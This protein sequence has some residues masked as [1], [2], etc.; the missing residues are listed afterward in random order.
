MTALGFIGAFLPVMPT[1]VFLLLA[2]F[3]FARS[4]P[5]F[6][7]WLL[8]H[9]QFGGLIR[10]WRAGRGLTLRAK[11]TAVS[12]IVVTVGSSALFFVP[13]LIGKLILAAVGIGVS[14]YL[15]TRPTKPA[16]QDG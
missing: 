1:T 4:S 12:L 3:F 13:S 15:I 14:S 2:A 11:I 16:S 7:R 8:D 5:K 6:Y 9:P 10:D